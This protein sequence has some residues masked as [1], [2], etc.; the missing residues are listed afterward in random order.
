[1]SIKKVAKDYKITKKGVEFTTLRKGKVVISEEEVRMLAKLYCPSKE[2]AKYFGISYQQIISHF[3]T[4]IEEEQVK[5]KQKLRAKQ[6]EEAYNGNTTLLIWL[7]K[8]MLGQTDQGPKHG[9]N[10]QPLPWS[11][12]E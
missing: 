8:Q 4:F 11:E 5:T 2:I 9:D 7:G 10:N 3:G 1:M 12:D 6:L